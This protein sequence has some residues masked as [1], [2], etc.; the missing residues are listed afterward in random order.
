MNRIRV[1][2]S[3]FIDEFG[4]TLL[5]RGINLGG[6]SKLPG[7]AEPSSS[8]GFYQHR[9][10]SFVNR[11]FPLDEA[12][13]HFGRLR[14]WGLTFLRLVVG[15]E[16]VEHAGP[17]QYDE[18]YLEYLY[19]LVCLAGKHGLRLFI[20][21][22]QDVW[23]RF[24]G[25]D[26]APGWTLEAVGLDI[27]QLHASGAA[28]L[29]PYNQNPL[30]L[31][32]TSNY[33]RLAAATM[34]TLFFGGND[35]APCTTI[36][37]EPAQT[38]LQRHYLN[39]FRQV[40]QKLRGLPHVAGYGTMNEPSPGFIGLTDLTA[41][42][43][44][45]VALGPS[46][47]PY[48]AML[49][50]A[51]YSQQVNDW[52][53]DW[54]GHRSRRKTTL[55]PDGVRAWQPGRD[56][57]WREHSVWDVD[58]NGQPRLLRPDHFATTNRGGQ[59]RPVDFAQDYLKPFI[60][61]YAQA[62]RAISPPA[63]IFIENTPTAPVPHWTAE[64]TPNV[65]NATHWYDAFTLFTALF[66]PFLSVDVQTRR[67][68]LGRKQVRDMLV[69]QLGAIK[70]ASQDQM[71]GAP[72][73]VGEFG[74]S[75]NM[76]WRLN[77]RFNWFGVQEWALDASFAALEAHLLSGTL[78]NYSSD[79]TNSLG[80]N[81]NGEDL[82]IF[83][84]DQQFNPADINSGGRAL[85]ALVRPYPCCTAGEPLFLHFDYR[86]RRFTFR[87][88]HNPAI[89]EPTEIYVPTFHYPNGY[90]VDLSDG[91]SETDASQQ[92]LRYWYS[93]EQETHT[94]ELRPTGR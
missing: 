24:S 75:Y 12:D 67:L 34:F 25:G 33:T 77:Y 88:R 10:V 35:F 60:N 80:D 65:V 59:S 3:H 46:P 73:L 32:W 11:P 2:G 38:Y 57:I 83:S 6:G 7:L 27:E 70:R 78:W 31:Q 86:Q 48:Q 44:W 36:E 94:L 22:H 50:G 37:G 18:A 28:S 19:Q 74:I 47:S 82:S 81:W 41:V 30:P 71:G 76:P 39:A 66:I 64:D 20:D 53:L 85:R 68:V 14:H 17:G 87:F 9:T 55:N 51:G 23:S 69:A 92:V 61:D 62:I 79:N 8:A 54:L 5:L 26:G 93:P 52:Q 89:R 63:L 90:T 13:E 45:H 4:R 58:S 1:E 91:R 43:P 72:T 21:P 29:H 49:L 42:H 15:W 56:C 84:R 40:A 16:A